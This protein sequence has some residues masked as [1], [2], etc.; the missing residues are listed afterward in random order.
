MEERYR[1]DYEGEFVIVGVKMVNGKK[2]QEREFVENPIQIKSISGRATCVSNGVSS[3]QFQID[4]LMLHHGLL[5]TLPLNVYTTGSLYNKVHANF[6]VTFNDAHLHE[7][8]DKKLTEDIIVYTSTT[9]CLKR[10]GEF[11]I[12]PYGYKST[13]E[14]VAAY[15]AAFDGHR[16]VFLVGYDEYTLDGLT[17][18]TKMIETVG[19]VIKTYS[20]TK[21]YHV[22]P[23]DNVPKEWLP[24]RNL[25][26]MAVREFISYCD[27]S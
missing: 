10:P 23:E 13:E 24:Y 22:T 11:F 18:R 20:A 12:V 1:N 2:Q 17:R 3:T 16:E 8:I 5:N 7:L 15:L 21:F 14:A 19:Q 4:R 9:Q 26:A 6:H 27:I 25:E